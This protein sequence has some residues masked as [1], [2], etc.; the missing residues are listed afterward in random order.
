MI[1]KIEG[2]HPEV[3]HLVTGH[4]H[5]TSGY[6]SWRANGTNDWLLIATLD[7]GGRFGHNGGE[8]LALPG[9]LTLLRPGTRHDYGARDSWEL[10]WT[11]FHPRPDW[12]PW[13][14]WPEAAPGLM[15]LTLR[16]PVIRQKI[17]TRFRDA[18]HLA[19]GALRHRETFAMNALEEMLL[20]CDTQNP[21]S[22]Q[23]RLDSRVREVMDYLVRRLAEPVT[24]HE[25]GAVSGLSSSRLSHLFR[26]QISLTPFQFL[27]GQRLNRAAQLLELTSRPV[28]AIAAEV[29]YENPFYFTLRFKRHTGL[30]PRD[31]RNK[32]G[33]RR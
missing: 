23:S 33:G 1:P 14:I 2:P 32:H 25:M 12:S 3:V 11:H 30:S 18:H 31:Y 17:L 15:R 16:E 8:F 9:D 24:S 4:F 13:L 20:W 10:L 21:L 28:A 7:G 22:E 19:T 5:E 27:E 6:E 26:A 29:G